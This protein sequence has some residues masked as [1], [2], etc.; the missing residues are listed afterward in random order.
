M[1]PVFIIAGN[2]RE[3]EEFTNRKYKEHPPTEPFPKYV[4]V[5]TVDT[6][7]GFH[8]PHG[9]FIGSYKSRGDI[10]DIVYQIATSSMNPIPD[11][12]V[13]LWNEVR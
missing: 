1:I 7:R 12:I 8:N 10:R 13:Q 2:L 9:L 3:F 11:I 6:L 4:Y 5:T